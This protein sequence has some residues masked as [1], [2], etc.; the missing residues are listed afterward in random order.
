MQEDNRSS[1]N[2]SNQRYIPKQ[3]PM[4]IMGII[5]VVVCYALFL[6]VYSWEAILFRVLDLAGIIRGK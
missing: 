5:I 3:L 6:M 1:Q 4:R 2:G